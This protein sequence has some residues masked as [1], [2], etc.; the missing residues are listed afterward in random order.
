MVREAIVEYV[1]REKTKARPPLRFLA[2]GRSGHA[3]TAERHEEL[4]FT[5]PGPT[6][7]TPSPARKPVK[8]PAGPRQR[9]R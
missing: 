5:E 2:F 9:R 8:T 4:L 7:P 6:R 3:D 1:A